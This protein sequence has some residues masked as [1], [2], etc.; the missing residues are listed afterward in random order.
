MCGAL[1]WGQQSPQQPCR[2]PIWQMRKLRHGS[3][4][5]PRSVGGLPTAEPPGKPGH[6]L[7]AGCQSGTRTGTP[8]ACFSASVYPYAEWG[9]TGDPGYSSQVPACT[10]YGFDGGR[11]GKGERCLETQRSTKC[12]I[13]AL[14]WK[15]LVRLGLCQWLSPPQT[16][17]GG[18][19][20]LTS[21]LHSQRNSSVSKR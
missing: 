20:R 3:G 13:S 6:Q 2:T 12:P 18:Q 5:M 19:A 9:C 15:L 7:Q 17:L 21:P 8:S 10:Q 11:R 16:L 4:F 14:P 1:L